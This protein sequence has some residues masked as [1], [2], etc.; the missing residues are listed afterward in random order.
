MWRVNMRFRLKIINLS[1]FILSSIVLSA[2]SDSAH[3][4]KEQAV[5]IAKREGVYMKCEGC[6]IWGDDVYEFNH[7]KIKRNRKKEIILNIH[8]ALAFDITT[9][10]IIYKVYLE[11]KQ[12]ASK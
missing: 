8:K 3:I 12:I 5:K 7:R 10:K 2:Q 11:E 9:G 1:F 6:M 4:T